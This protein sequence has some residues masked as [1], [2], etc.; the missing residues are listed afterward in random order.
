MTAALRMQEFKF[1]IA[2]DCKK[3]RPFIIHAERRRV[4]RQ[5]A[6]VRSR[7]NVDDRAFAGVGTMSR[8]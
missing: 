4:R 6:S 7:A 5:A 1:I 3:I 2:R 8:V